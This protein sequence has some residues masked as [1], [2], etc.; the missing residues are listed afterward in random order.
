MKYICLVE[1]TDIWKVSLLYINALPHW[2]LHDYEW[3]LQM[4][5]YSRHIVEYKLH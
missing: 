1:S 4:P 5:I 3:C 2:Y